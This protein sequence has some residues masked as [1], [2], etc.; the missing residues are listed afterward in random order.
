[1]QK[2]FDRWNKKKQIIHHENESKLYH[3]RELW[4]CSL[5]VNVGSE[6]DGTGDNYDRPVLIITGLS[7]QTCMV[8]PL[9]SSPEI[10]KM[11]VPIGEVQGANAS[12]I[13]SQI[14]VVD[15]KRLIYKIGF[16][17]K[18]NFEVVTKTVK[19]LL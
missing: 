5:G 3:A 4:W 10:H 19:G 16:L 2:D 8:V 11:R 15:T 12:V 13:I 7:K 1:M 14:R 17:N 6:Q 18:K 9:T